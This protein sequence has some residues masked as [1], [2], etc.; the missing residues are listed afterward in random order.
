M[1]GLISTS[2]CMSASIASR[3]RRLKTSYMC[4]VRST[5]S[6]D[7]LLFSIARASGYRFP[8]RGGTS[9]PNRFTPPLRKKQ[10]LRTLG[11]Q[12]AEE[13]RVSL[14]ELAELDPVT[15]HCARVDVGEPGPVRD[16]DRVLE[17][18]V[19]LPKQPLDLPPRLI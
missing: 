17:R 6:R 8:C 14:L 13:V 1:R 10:Q 16:Q 4:K 11:Y 19:V 9:D 18:Q 3:S 2:S 15:E 12:S 5:F 7:I